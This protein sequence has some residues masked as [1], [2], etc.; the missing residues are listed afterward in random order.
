MNASSLEETVRHA[1]ELLAAG[2]HERAAAL[3]ERMLEM[4]AGRADGH[5]GLARLHYGQ[6]RQDEA[7]RHL[8]LA[9]D[10]RPSDAGILGELALVLRQIGL[11]GEASVSA[12][13]AAQLAPG[14]IDI[15][16]LNGTLLLLNG[17]YAEGWAAWGRA[18]A[19]E[20]TAGDT[21]RYRPPRWEG[22]R[23]DG[24]TLL[25]DAG[26]NDV[27]AVQFSRYLPALRARGAVPA[28]AC[29]EAAAGLLSELPGLL[30]LA[31]P[32]EN[33]PPYDLTVGFDD[34]P[35]VFETTPA[36]VPPPAGLRVNPRQ[37]RYWQEALAGAPSPRIAVAWSGVEPWP[38]GL[39]DLAGAHF[40]T[41]LEP[42]P[43]M[44]PLAD[45]PFALDAAAALLE[46]FEMVV[47]DDNP[48]GHLAGT[49]GRPCWM[50]LGIAPDWRWLQARR[51]TPWYPSMRLV[52]QERAGD[53]SVP[54]AIVRREIERGLA[55][56]A[57]RLA[58][59]EAALAEGQV[60]R[61]AALLAAGGH[62]WRG[63]ARMHRLLGDLALA[64]DR[65]DDA[66]RALH[67]AVAAAPGDA[68][69][70]S[71]FAGVLARIGAH[72]D[73]ERI[74]ARAVTLDPASPEPRLQHAAALEALGR[75]DEA[76][77]VYTD[78][79]DLAPD[80]RAT[81]AALA[82][83]LL[84]RGDFDAGL[85]LLPAGPLPPAGLRAVRGAEVIIDAVAN[86]IEAIW[87]LRYAPLLESAGRVLAA[88]R[89]GL[90][91]LIAGLDGVDG[92]LVA[93]QA[94]PQG[95]VTLPA[96]ALPRLFGTTLETIPA[97]IPYIRPNEMLARHW[98]SRFARPARLRVG[99]AWGDRALLEA[100]APLFD[101]EGAAFFSLE[102]EA[103]SRTL[104]ALRS[105]AG[106]TDISTR[107]TDAAELAAAI[108][109]LDMVIG[110]DGPAVHVAGAL[111]VPAAVL[112]T[113][114]AHWRWLSDLDDSPWYPAS[115]LFRQERLDDWAAPVAELATVL[116]QA[117][118]D[119]D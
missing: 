100:M 78:A 5:L 38:E 112:L 83:A 106:I 73:R 35:R 12:A 22:R 108:S 86:D 88:V 67:R 56:N 76:L 11:T 15:H 59:A 3:Y 26:E 40:Y 8:R 28:I 75:A 48:I 18:R 19:L 81:A 42:V 72:R 17:R 109:S 55:R 25:V 30:W 36:T 16:W 45:A 10:L 6:G 101:T 70:H 99:V 49:L 110:P 7:A 116:K 9:A 115:R 44:E 84:S 102:T 87:L 94:R 111:G 62:P 21:S 46:E 107:I 92:V 24:E 79:H 85:P 91:R 69:V 104:A 118:F 90:Q 71:A 80:D 47:S 68:G 37:R 96:A 105:R 119:A 77:E 103:G 54:L 13:R 114:P 32:G 95:A 27:D 82:S 60:R 57:D 93:G 50:M 34:L 2:D 58:A 65:L 97:N 4:E 29:S 53:W 74:A 31:A 98:R 41:F 1:A 117:I 14:D 20:D 43:G 51:D 23:L 61:A 113:R 33:R 66:A 89:P 39:R 63:D 52:R 64:Q